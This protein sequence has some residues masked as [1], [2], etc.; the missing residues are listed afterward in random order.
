M[1][2]DHGEFGNVPHPRLLVHELLHQTNTLLILEH[3]DLDASLFE[4]LLPAHEA[5]VLPDHHSGHLVHNTSARTHV[6][7][8]KGSVHCCTR[9]G[10]SRKSS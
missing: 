2:L 8:A 5:L 3:H 9:V 7:R 4:V 6:A 10:R 1:E